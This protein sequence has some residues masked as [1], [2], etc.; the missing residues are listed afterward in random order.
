MGRIKYST[1]NG[2]KRRQRLKDA[3]LCIICGKNRPAEGMFSCQPCRDLA[4]KKRPIYHRNSKLKKKLVKV[5]KLLNR[6]WVDS[7][8][9]TMLLDVCINTLYSWRNSGYIEVKI[10]GPDRA[11]WFSEA[12]IKRL[13]KVRPYVICNKCQYEWKRCK[14]IDGKPIFCPKCN[15]RNYDVMPVWKK[16][17]AEYDDILDVRG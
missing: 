9:A 11:L 12:D 15:H 6:G 17:R 14:P 1:A 10:I 13:N 16:R 7:S 5:D 2:R 4:N 8:Q 3:G